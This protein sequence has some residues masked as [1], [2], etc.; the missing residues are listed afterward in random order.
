MA[1]LNGSSTRMP[2]SLAVRAAHATLALAAMDGRPAQEAAEA[3][4]AAG[5]A[6]PGWFDSS[7]ELRRGLDVHEGLPD[8]ASV[9]EW[10]T[11]FCLRA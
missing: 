10:L 7:W 1:R 2:P 4:D 3:A 6:G 8:D 5:H 9:D 11:V